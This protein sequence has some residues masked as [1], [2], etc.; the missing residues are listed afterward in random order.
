MVDIIVIGSGLSGLRTAQLLSK[1]A[2][3][4]T[5]TVLEASVRLSVSSAASRLR[6]LK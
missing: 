4:N 2:Q 1:S 6:I 5:I 3:V